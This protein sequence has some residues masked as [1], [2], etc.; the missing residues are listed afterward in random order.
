MK[1]P[2][3]LVVSF[4][5]LLVGC[6]GDD[7]NSSTASSTVPNSELRKGLGPNGTA[8]DAANA[9]DKHNAALSNAADAVD[10][11]IEKPTKDGSGVGQAGGAPSKPEKEIPDHVHGPN[12]N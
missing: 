1:L 8:Q 10:D 12:R 2:N 3:V 6:G 5:I 7:S 11:H 4:A 9:M